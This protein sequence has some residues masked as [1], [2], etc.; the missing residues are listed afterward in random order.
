M[1]KRERTNEKKQLS[2]M[3]III[4]I[5]KTKHYLRIYDL[6]LNDSTHLLNEIYTL[7][8]CSDLSIRHQVLKLH[9][10][11]IYWIRTLKVFLTKYSL[12]LRFYF[13]QTLDLHRKQIDTMLL[14]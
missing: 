4:L 13:I 3:Q 10:A 11:I 12:L 1:R 6:R 5:E 9:L 7:T 14:C 2:L 8:R